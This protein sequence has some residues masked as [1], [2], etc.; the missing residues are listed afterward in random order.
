MR[1]D[2]LTIGSAKPG[3]AQQFKN[4]KD[5]SI[6]FDQRHWIT[7]IIGWNGTGKSNVLEALATIFR[8]LISGERRPSF[9]YSLDYRIGSGANTL[10]INVD[11]DPDRDRE[12][13]IIHVATDAEIAAGTGTLEDKPGRPAPKG[14]KTALKSFFDSEASYL[15]R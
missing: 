11:A 1:L 9:A 15:P 4:L 8:D 6:D 14:R 5:V 13:L 12:A 7:V 10:Y 2:K 3:P